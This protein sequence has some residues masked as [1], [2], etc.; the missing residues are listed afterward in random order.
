MAHD[1]YIISFSLSHLEWEH[2]IDYLLVKHVEMTQSN[3]LSLSVI[4]NHMDSQ[5]LVILFTISFLTIPISVQ[6][7]L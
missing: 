5:Y 1:D 6:L 2:N 4:A 3:P 7:E